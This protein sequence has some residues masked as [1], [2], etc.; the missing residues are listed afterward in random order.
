MA[1]NDFEVVIVG[2]GAAGIAAGRR[3]HEA[4]VDC[5]IVE[6]RRRLGGRAWTVVDGR[7]PA[8]PWL[9][10]AAFGRAQS[11][12]ARSLRRRA[13]RS[14]RR[15]RPGCERR[16]RS[17]S[18]SRSNRAFATRCALLRPARR[19]LPKGCTG[20]SGAA[21][22]LQPDERWN[23]L[24]GAVSTFLSG[25]RARAA[26]RTR[27]RSLRRHRRELARGRG[28]WRDDR[29]PCRG[30]AGRLGCRGAAR[31]IIRGKRRTSRD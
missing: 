13:A 27:L 11:M 2:G 29:R 8:R 5:L 24:I 23:E 18:R 28:L 7:S 20:R 16:I 25:A 10:L 4:G 6:A 17:A 26:L 15:R 14:T 31:S 21:S 22:L 30:G 12:D 3:L 1:K 19:S 9:R